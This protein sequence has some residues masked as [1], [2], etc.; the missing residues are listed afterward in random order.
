MSVKKSILRSI[1][2]ATALLVAPVLAQQ[3]LYRWT[4]EQGNQ[5]NSDRPPAA[6]VEYEVISIQSNMVQ[7][8][9]ETSSVETEQNGAAVD[10]S[11]PPLATLTE[12][13]AKQKQNAELC[14][15]ATENLAILST[16]A[17]IR[18]QDDAGEVRYLSEDEKAA[19]QRQA[20]NAIKDY[21]P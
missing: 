11:D 10:Q 2:A 21:C 4:D 19:Q 14:K 9:D 12:T 8:A 6:G 3:S 15:L 1:A 17:R 16:K 18:M 13:E 20:E 7:A 5:V